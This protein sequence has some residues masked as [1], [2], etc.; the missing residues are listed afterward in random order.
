MDI[1]SYIPLPYR[2]TSSKLEPLPIKKNSVNSEALYQLGIM[3]N[4]YSDSVLV[5]NRES[6]Y[7][8]INSKYSTKI[9]KSIN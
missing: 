7:S 8:V 5:T 3:N 2:D 1:I 6:K 9:I 4:P